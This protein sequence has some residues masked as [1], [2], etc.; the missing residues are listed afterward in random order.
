MNSRSDATLHFD[1]VLAETKRR[2]R[3]EL[4]EPAVACLGGHSGA[5]GPIVPEHIK[6]QIQ[7]SLPCTGRCVCAHSSDLCFARR[8]IAS[9]ACPC[10]LRC[11]MSNN[12]R[13]IRLPNSGD[14]V[15]FHDKQKV[16][17]GSN[18]QIFWRI[19][20]VFESCC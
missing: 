3:E 4:T 5:R 18:L 20:G 16:T 12:C 19:V 14:G 6:A 7:A 13:Y 15:N 8:A 17:L 2:I 1:L 10:L 11:H 9:S